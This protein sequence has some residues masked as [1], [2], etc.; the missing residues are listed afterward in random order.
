MKSRFFRGTALL[1]LMLLSGLL[2]ADARLIQIAESRV[3]FEVPDKWTVTDDDGSWLLQSPDGGAVSLAFAML[4]N[5]KLDEAIKKCEQEVTSQVGALNYTGDSTEGELNGMM[6][7][8]QFATAMD[9]QM[10][11]GIT[12]VLTPAQKWLMITYFGAVAH[13]RTWEKD[14]IQI[15]GSIS[16]F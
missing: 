15:A 1:V 3:Q 11:V 5:E 6:Y 2:S 7:F 13:E 10:T 12:L 16:P 14:V 4:A 8:E 9:G